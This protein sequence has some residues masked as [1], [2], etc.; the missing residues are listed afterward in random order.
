M[1]LF[2]RYVSIR[3][4][5][6]KGRFVREVMIEEYEFYEYRADFGTV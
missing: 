5:I 6:L 4:V 2:A 3:Q 1:T